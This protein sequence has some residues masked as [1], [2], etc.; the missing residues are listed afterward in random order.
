M[1]LTQRLAAR[2]GHDAPTNSPDPATTERLRAD[3]LATEIDPFAADPTEARV[4]ITANA[5]L[6]IDLR[7][8]AVVGGPAA[9]TDMPCPNCQ[10]DLRVDALD[11]VARTATMSCFT[12][13]FTF[14]PRLSSGHR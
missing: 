5:E 13:G 2:R 3:A 10:S 11:P 12:C 1:K 6:V 8:A 14:S 4:H 9:T 7:P